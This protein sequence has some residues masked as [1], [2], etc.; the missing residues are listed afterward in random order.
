MIRKLDHIAIA[1]GNMEEA[2]GFYRKMLGLQLKD[3]EVV[4]EQK[5]RV[6]FFLVGETRIELVEPASQDSPLVRFL[7]TRGPGIHHLCFEVDDIESEIRSLAEKGAPLIDKAPRPGAHG[8]RVA[9]LHP[10][11]TGG[12]LIE[13]SEKPQDG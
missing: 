13:L 10:K 12:V 3:T 11:G 1:V 2:A 6:G 8:T 5:T 7:E 4:E 9:F